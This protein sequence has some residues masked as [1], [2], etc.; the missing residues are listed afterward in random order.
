MI[1]ALFA[2]R[3]PL[4]AHVIEVVDIQSRVDDSVEARGHGG[5]VTRQA[6]VGAYAARLRR[7][8]VGVDRMY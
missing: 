5:P 8:P 3:P 1:V 6:G 2:G 7:H 4:N